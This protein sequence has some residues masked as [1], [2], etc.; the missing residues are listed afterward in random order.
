MITYMT[1]YFRYYYPLE[2]ITSYLNNATNDED[3]IDGTTLANM[4]GIKINNPK[5]GKSTAHYSIKDGEIYKGIESILYISKN[6]SDALLELS[7]ETLTFPELIE[8]AMANPNINSRQL[9]VLIKIDF[10]SEFGKARK[11]YEWFIRFDEYNGRKTFKKEG[12]PSGTEKIIMSFINKQHPDFSETAKQYKVNSSLIL[13]MIFKLMRDV[14]FEPRERI[15]NQLSY[16]GYLQD[17]SLK[18][19]PIGTI[20]TNRTKNDSYLINGMGWYKFSPEIEQP[21]KGDMIMI[22]LVSKVKNGRYMENMVM[23]YDKIILDRNTR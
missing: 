20:A 14:D 7:K 2:F 5:Y 1:A 18:S 19:Y 15:V 9:K 10:F 17:D 23:N 11:L 4:K 12:I 21:V 3:I 6:C 22:N 16:I 8:R 13:E